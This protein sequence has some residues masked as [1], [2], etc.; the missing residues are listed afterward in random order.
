MRTM[1]RRRS[2]L[3]FGLWLLILTFLGVPSSW[4]NGLLFVSGV[5]LILAALYL[6]FRSGSSFVNVNHDT[7]VDNGG[8]KVSEVKP[9]I[10]S[11]IDE[12]AVKPEEK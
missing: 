12:K 1:I 11:P 9:E 6:R 3:F 10:Q 5:F 2:I 8:L 7:Y 4:K